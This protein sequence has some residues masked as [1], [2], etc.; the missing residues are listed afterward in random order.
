M[1]TSSLPGTS[2]LPP[3]PLSHKSTV[4]ERLQPGGPEVTDLAADLRPARD[5]LVPSLPLSAV[6]SLLQVSRCRA[7]EAGSGN[8]SVASQLFRLVVR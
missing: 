2:S 5:Q 3:P 6:L 1:L 4:A 7:S 8:T